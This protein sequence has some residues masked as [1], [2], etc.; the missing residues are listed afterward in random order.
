MAGVR[1]PQRPG[2]KYDHSG[3][4][5]SQILAN[6]KEPSPYEMHRAEMQAALFCEMEDG[7]A[8]VPLGRLLLSMLGRED[9]T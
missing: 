1:V 9:W 5:H 3:L 2:P 6:V 7:S 8:D 4:D